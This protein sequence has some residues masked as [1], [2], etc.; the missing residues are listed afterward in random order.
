MTGPIPASLGGLTK[1]QLDLS[2]NQLPKYRNW[3]ASPKV[4]WLYG[5]SGPIPAVGLAKDAGP[6]AEPVEVARYRRG[7]SKLQVLALRTS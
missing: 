3:A 1:A 5:L 4:L 7:R 6:L 2:Q